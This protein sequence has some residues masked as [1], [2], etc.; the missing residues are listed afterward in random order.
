VREA[1]RAGG[2]RPVVEPFLLVDVLGDYVYL[3]L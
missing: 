3:P 1:S 2:H